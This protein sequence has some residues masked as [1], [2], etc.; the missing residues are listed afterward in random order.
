MDT[1]CWTTYT[2]QKGVQHNGKESIAE[3]VSFIQSNLDNYTVKQMCSALKFT[4]S[5]Y[6]AAINHVTSKR[7]EEYNEFSRQVL[8]V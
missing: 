2:Y 1:K 3:Y 8:S 4:R 6:Y 5:T 7:E